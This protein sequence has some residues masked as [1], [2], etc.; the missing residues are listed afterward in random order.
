M[1]DHVLPQAIPDAA[2]A[3]IQSLPPGRVELFSLTPLDRTGIACWNVIFLPADGKPFQGETP[4]GVGYG[5][6]DADAIVGTTGERAA[7]GA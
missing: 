6:T 7:P 3:Y 5:V 1:T 2:A 4:H